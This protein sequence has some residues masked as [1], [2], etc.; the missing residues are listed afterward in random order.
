MKDTINI[1]HAS[2][3]F[4]NKIHGFN[5]KF[6]VMDRSNQKSSYI[7][8]GAWVKP[9]EEKDILNN[10]INGFKSIFRVFSN[11]CINGIF[12]ELINDSIII[13]NIEYTDNDNYLQTIKTGYTFISIELTIF[14]KSE[15]D[16]KSKEMKDKHQLVC[17]SIVDLLLENRDLSFVPKRFK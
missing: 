3:H 2:I 12:G 6:G 7:A 17:S 9:K 14:F 8:V 15:I 1:K 11:K 16:I 4:S 5:T 13:R 10:H